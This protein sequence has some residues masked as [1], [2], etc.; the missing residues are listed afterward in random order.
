[1]LVE[2]VVIQT[3]IPTITFR[4]V[5]MLAGSR[6]DSGYAFKCLVGLISRFVFVIVL[7]PSG[8]FERFVRNFKLSSWS[9]RSQRQTT[10]SARTIL[11]SLPMRPLSS[12]NPH[13]FISAR[14]RPGIFKNQQPFGWKSSSSSSQGRSNGESNNEPVPQPVDPRP[15]WLFTS[16]AFLR[17]DYSSGDNLRRILP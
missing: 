12:M 15:S 9:Q 11:N 16:S 5:L 8:A 7:S 4:I 17:I 13:Y 6:L 2:K 1:M 10:K 3:Q 14:G